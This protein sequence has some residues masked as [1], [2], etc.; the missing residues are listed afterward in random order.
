MIIW[1]TKT[2]SILLMM[3]ATLQ[4]VKP[5]NIL[6]IGSGKSTRYFAE[7]AREYKVNFRSI[8]ENPEW[9]ARTNSELEISQLSTNHVMHVPIVG[10]WFDPE[11]MSDMLKDIQSW[12]LL[13]V[14]APAGSGLGKR[15]STRAIEW[16][17]RLIQ[18]R[19]TLIIDDVHRRHNYEQ[20]NQLPVKFRS[21]SFIFFT[22]D[23]GNLHPNVIAIVSKKHRHLK[24][25][26]RSLNLTFTQGLRN[27]EALVHE[28]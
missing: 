23:V 27:G 16:L 24:K 17:A 10:D 20:L 9:V 6:E 2:H 26:F 21:N 28:A 18:D 14:D 15:S 22:Y 4:V 5:I 11:A 13:F 7:Y 3:Q 25:S 8:E 19:T 1:P 12:D